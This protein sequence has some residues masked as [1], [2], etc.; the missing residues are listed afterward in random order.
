MNKILNCSYIENLF[1][2]RCWYNDIKISRNILDVLSTTQ[3]LELF[4]LHFFK[5]NHEAIVKMSSGFL[6]TGYSLH[7]KPV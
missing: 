6:R 1:I 3:H 4:V 7:I 2:L 5:S